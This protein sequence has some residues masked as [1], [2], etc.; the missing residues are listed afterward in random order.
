MY[1]KLCAVI[2]LL[3]TYLHFFSHSIVFSIMSGISASLA[4]NL[5]H[6]FSSMCPFAY[7]ISN[8][9]RYITDICTENALVEATEISGPACV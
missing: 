3:E 7:A 4:V 5:L 1:N 9:R 6:S 8:A 2:N